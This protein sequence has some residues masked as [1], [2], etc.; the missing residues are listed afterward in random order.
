MSNPISNLKS[1]ELLRPQDLNCNVFSVYDYDGFSIQE[2]LCEF[3][4]KINECVEIANATFKL[5]EWLV[6]VGLAQEVAKMLEKWLAD[7]TLATIINE[8]IFKELNDK[9]N[10]NIESIN[11]LDISVKQIT[12]NVKDFGAKGDGVTDDIV[13]IQKAI[14]TLVNGGEVYF[15]IGKY[16]ISKPIY[17][18]TRVTLRGQG[19]DETTQILKV[20]GGKTEFDILK[21]YENATREE[22]MLYDA[23][24]IFECDG[25]YSGIKD[26][27]IRSVDKLN[28][29]KWGLLAPFT[30]L[31]IFE[32]FTVYDFDEP[33]RIFNAWNMNWNGIRTIRS[34]Y[35]IRVEDNRPDVVGACTSWSMNRIFCEYSDYGYKFRGLQ[36][37]SLNSVCADQ[38]NKRAYWFDYSIGISVNGMGCENSTCQILKSNFSQ[39]SIN[40]YFFLG[41]KPIVN[42]PLEM[43]SDS[44][45]EVT[46]QGR[47]GCGLILNSGEFKTDTSNLYKLYGSFH[48]TINCYNVRVWD[49]KP[50]MEADPTSQ[51][52]ITW[53]TFDEIKTNKK[54]MVN[55]V[56]L[57]KVESSYRNDGT[58]MQHYG[59][60]SVLNNVGNG[61]SITSLRIPRNEI[62]KN[63][64]W[65]NNNDNYQWI[66]LKIS[67]SSEWHGDCNLIWNAHN[68]IVADGKISFGGGIIRELKTD[69][70]DLIIDFNS[71]VSRT[72]VVI[73]LA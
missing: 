51:A 31:D 54:I 32:N 27:N 62:A 71:E 23:C 38:I 29:S 43:T 57:E 30:Q 64:S 2:L 70:N 14:D 17:V 5:A 55:D 36:Y 58:S 67:V 53:D 26:I 44:L 19:S 48:A 28:R 7:G 20:K 49:G 11:R 1:L 72:K 34:E 15:P 56:K 45:I 16:K 40:G 69:A 37:S 59:G 39:I 13:S 8:T 4:E 66:P 60:V 42:R 50:I 3:F 9:V 68:T 46:N 33:I 73:S 65:V 21:N 10:T 63:F 22:M 61:T 35:G 18:P 47:L 24:I 25:A 12:V 41:L 52:K 6:S